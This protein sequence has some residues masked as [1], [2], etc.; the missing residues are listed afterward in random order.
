M[1]ISHWCREARCRLAA[2]VALALCASM[3]GARPAHGQTDP[4]PSWNEGPAKQAILSFVKQTT[5]KAGPQY[6]APPDRIATFDQDSTLWV[7]DWKK[8]FAF[9]E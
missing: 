4:L 8:I 6:V 5:G 7:K 2:V 1:G 9:G 3:P